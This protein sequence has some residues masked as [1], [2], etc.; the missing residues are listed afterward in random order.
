MNEM[1][2]SSKEIASLTGKRHDNVK[3]TIDSLVEE[4]VVAFPQIEEKVT[5]GRPL[6]EYFV[7]ERDSY[8]I[9]AQLSPQFTAKLVDRWRALESGEAKPLVKGYNRRN[10]CVH[11]AR[12][13]SQG[14]PGPPRQGI[15]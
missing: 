1:K 2:I 6:R 3:R 10:T 15:R 4:K 13:E 5:G 14:I 11:G 9:V 12:Y 8:V 7:G